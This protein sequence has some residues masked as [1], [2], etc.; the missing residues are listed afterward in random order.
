MKSKTILS[1]TKMVRDPKMTS[2]KFAQLIKSKSKPN[3]KDNK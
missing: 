3:Q 1:L 2:A